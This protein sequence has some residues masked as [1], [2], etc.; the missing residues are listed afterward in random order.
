M[1]SRVSDD[2]DDGVDDAGVTGVTLL[3]FDSDGDFA[4]IT[5]DE[6]FNEDELVFTI[7]GRDEL[8]PKIM[9]AA[10]DDKCLSSE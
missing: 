3:L 4:E 1:T 7:V 10:D 5:G 2:S 8:S 6:E 9:L